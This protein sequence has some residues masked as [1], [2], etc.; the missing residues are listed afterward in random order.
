[1]VSDCVNVFVSICRIAFV[2]WDFPNF[3][4]R[5]KDL[6]GRF[7]MQKRHLQLAGFIVVEVRQ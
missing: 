3:C 7:A 2:S 6:L 4:L 1:M 5:S